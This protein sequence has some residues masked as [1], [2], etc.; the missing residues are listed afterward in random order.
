VFSDHPVNDAQSLDAAKVSGIVCNDCQ[1]F[2][3]RNRRN[4][5]IN[6][7]DQLSAA[8]EVCLSFG[9][10]HGGLMREG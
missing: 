1:T 5:E 8:L 7:A 4:Q 9:S 2:A 6:F 3:K 10:Q